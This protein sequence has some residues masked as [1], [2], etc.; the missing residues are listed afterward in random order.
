MARI[1]SRRKGKSGSKKPAEKKADW[2][3]LKPAEIEAVIVKLAKQGMGSAQIGLVLRDQ[4]GVPN[5]RMFT[6][7]KIAGVMKEKGLYPKELP[8]DMFNLVRRAV[9]LSNH[10]QKNKHDYT[11][12]RGYE[13]T[14]SKIRRLARYYKEQGRL[15]L[16]W[17]WDIEQA[18]LLVK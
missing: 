8:E 2:V 6:Q 9:N 12:L 7:K 5:A 4:Y 14:E 3:K 10:L 13:I 18:K 17:R 11:S 15:P 16:N 1:Y